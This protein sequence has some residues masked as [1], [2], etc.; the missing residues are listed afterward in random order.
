MAQKELIALGS[1][2]AIEAILFAGR[3]VAKAGRSDLTP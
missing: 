1:H 3:I 2:E